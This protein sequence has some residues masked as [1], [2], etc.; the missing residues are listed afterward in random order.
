[1]KRDLEKKKQSAVCLSLLT[2]AGTA[3]GVFG[4]G[5]ILSTFIVKKKEVEEQ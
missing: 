1:M 3:L 5:L 2:V 4:T